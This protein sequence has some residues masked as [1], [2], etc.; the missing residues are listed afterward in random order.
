MLYAIFHDWQDKDIAYQI[1]GKTKL[2]LA[3]LK[4]LVSM[5]LH[6]SQLPTLSAGQQKQLLNHA[7]DDAEKYPT[8]HSMRYTI[9]KDVVK[10]LHKI[11][12][13]SK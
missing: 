2:T 13:N 4:T 1:D 7:M 5:C 10:G 11:A 6:N 8:S 12:R 9:L 3:M